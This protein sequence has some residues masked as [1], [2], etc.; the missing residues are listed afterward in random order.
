MLLNPM[1]F[2]LEENASLTPLS[3]MGVLTGLAR[4]QLSDLY[5]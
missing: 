1:L 2:A 4:K 3:F 5:S